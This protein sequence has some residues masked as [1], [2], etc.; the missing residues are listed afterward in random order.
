M[1]CTCKM[2]RAISCAAHKRSPQISSRDAVS[3]LVIVAIC[4]TSPVTTLVG[5]ITHLNICVLCSLCVHACRC[6]CKKHISLIT[7][8]S[9]HFSSRSYQQHMPSKGCWMEGTLVPRI[10]ELALVCRRQ[11][12]WLTKC[13]WRKGQLLPFQIVP[14]DL[15]VIGRLISLTVGKT[16]FSTCHPFLYLQ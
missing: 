16:Y 4:G 1:G 5:S 9:H 2:L 13:P 3:I 7:L 14:F 6:A 15:S 12:G 11:R 10:E 8:Y